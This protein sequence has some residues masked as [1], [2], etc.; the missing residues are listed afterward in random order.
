MVDSLASTAVVIILVHLVQMIARIEYFNQTGGDLH[1]VI[2]SGMV[3]H[4]LGDIGP[5]LEAFGFDLGIFAIFTY[6]FKL[7][8]R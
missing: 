2:T 4:S 1:L 7:R 8:Y 6:I 3:I 5:H